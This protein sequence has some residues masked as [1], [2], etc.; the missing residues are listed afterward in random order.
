MKGDW[1]P[2]RVQ[3]RKPAEIEGLELDMRLG[4]A[5][6]ALDAANRAVT[7]DTGDVVSGDGV[8]IATGSAPRALPNQ[9]DLDGVVDAAHARRLARTRAGAG[10]RPKVVVIGAGFIGLEVAATAAQTG[11]AS[12][13]VLEGAAGSADPRAR[14]RDGR[15]VAAGPRRNGVTVRC[16][17]QVTAIEGEAA[18]HAGCCLADGEIVAADVVVVGIGVAPATRMAG[19]QRRSNCVTASSVTTTAA[20]PAARRVRRRRL[21]PLGQQAVR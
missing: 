19:R 14:R 2:E 16:G 21:R 4:V 9:P 15:V 7:L 8:I 5:A 11:A 20:R 6:T 17:V 1:E 18:G 12:V 3:L 10:R 13:T